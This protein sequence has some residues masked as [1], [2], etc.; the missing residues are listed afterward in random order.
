M[1][2]PKEY[3]DNPREAELAE[4]VWI[5]SAKLPG[6]YELHSTNDWFAN[7]KWPWVNTR[8]IYARDWI[9][10]YREDDG[11]G[12]IHSVNSQLGGTNFT[13]KEIGNVEH[14]YVAAM[15]GSLGGPAG[16]VALNVISSVGWEL[17]IGPVRIIAGG[18]SL[19]GLWKNIKHNAGQ[20]AGPDQA[21]MRFGSFYSIREAAQEL[22]KNA[23]TMGD[24][25]MMPPLGTHPV[26]PKDWLSK[27]ADIWY[28][29]M[30][31]WPII[32]DYNRDV[33]GNDPNKIRPGQ[34][35]D[36]PDLANYSD[37]EI[38]EAVRRGK[39]WKKSA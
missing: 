31:K 36:I 30:Y 4:K 2:T 7:A 23:P 35:L 24:E 10:Y 21:G 5:L 29:D 8:I 32:Y 14:F 37:V 9:T 25:I 1:T 11:V 33:I 19:E 20:V 22:L 13:A 18:T 38:A 15:T 26:G 39:A 6:K 16:G 28:H 27:I 34:Q 12:G 17:L 3:F